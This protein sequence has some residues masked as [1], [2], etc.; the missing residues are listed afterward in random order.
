MPTTGRSCPPGV[1]GFSGCSIPVSDDSECHG[2]VS[3]ELTG[4]TSRKGLWMDT[5]GM[6]WPGRD[7]LE[8]STHVS[9]IG[10]VE[11][12][13]VTENQN[14]GAGCPKASIAYHV[15]TF[16][17]T[18]TQALGTIFPNQLRIRYCRS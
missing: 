8:D 13:Y 5:L 14:D 7:L 18:V 3:M 17:Q 1:F 4:E 12:R 16:A 6:S 9:F 15:T 10:S 2:D 11:D